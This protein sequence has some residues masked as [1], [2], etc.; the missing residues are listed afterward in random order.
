[1]CHTGKYWYRET[2]HLLTHDLTAC[3]ISW[4]ASFS[5]RDEEMEV[6]GFSKQGWN[7]SY[8]E[9]QVLASILVYRGLFF[10]A[11]PF[12]YL[13]SP[14]RTAVVLLYHGPEATGLWGTWG[15]QKGDFINC[16]GQLHHLCPIGFGETV[17]GAHQYL[18][19]Q[20]NCPQV[21]LYTP[22]K[23]SYEVWNGFTL[24][25]GSW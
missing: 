18:I 11:R 15:T 25:C 13:P 3:S 7:W 8:V 24:D 9:N 4:Q 12:D 1:M 10:S 6:R 23:Y 21:D 14:V 16:D 22:G 19:R 2:W 17:F 20:Y 5:P